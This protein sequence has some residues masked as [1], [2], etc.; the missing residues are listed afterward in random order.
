MSNERERG[1]E[2]DKTPRRADA[3]RASNAPGRTSDSAGLRTPTAPVASGILTRPDA[4]ADAAVDR[5]SASSGQGLPEDLRSRFEGSLNADL[6]SVRVHTGPESQAAA[7]AVSARAFAVGDDI[8]FA[9]GQYDPQSGAGQQLIAHE[10]AHTVQ[11]RGASP[12]RQHKLAISAPGDAFET[13]ADR[14][15]EAMVAGIATSVSRGGVAIARKGEDGTCEKEKE[16]ETLEQ[17][18]AKTQWQQ[19]FTAV[20]NDAIYLEGCAHDINMIAKTDKGVPEDPLAADF[21]DHVAAIGDEWRALSGR[22]GAALNANDV[23]AAP[24]LESRL[25][26]LDA[27]VFRAKDD[28]QFYQAA[29]DD[30]RATC[31]GDKESARSMRIIA[32]ETEAIRFEV[33]VLTNTLASAKQKL[34]TAVGSLDNQMLVTRVNLLINFTAVL[35][36]LDP[37]GVVGLGFDIMTTATGMMEDKDS[38]DGLSGGTALN[39]V[40]TFAGAVE[41]AAPVAAKAG[42]IV[43]LCADVAGLLLQATKDKE[44]LD[45]RSQRVLAAQAALSQAGSE[46]D[47]VMRRYAGKLNKAKDVAQRANSVCE[48]KR[49]KIKKF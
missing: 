48:Q 26:K 14:A 18:L 31:G 6:S 23:C 9:D 35:L 17:K 11:Q 3:S 7:S 24:E 38:K 16:E 46:L 10:V 49:G 45:A 34:E 33:G 28:L 12:V 37:T 4:D 40:G 2:R 44:Q 15:A 8:H 47:D 19:Q 41:Q 20:K 36:N 13:E 1:A 30:Y 39:I 21:I 32:R 43:G 22:H 25:D 29:L 5:A 42:G 27:E